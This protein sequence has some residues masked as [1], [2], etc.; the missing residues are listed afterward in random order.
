[1][2][3]TCYIPVPPDSVRAP[4]HRSLLEGVVGATV[5]A[6]HCHDPDTCRATLDWAQLLLA[7]TAFTPPDPATAAAAI[8]RQAHAYVQQQQQQQQQLLAAQQH[9]GMQGIVRQQFAGQGMFGAPQRPGFGGSGF[10]GL[11]GG[12]AAHAPYHNHQRGRVG[13][14]GAGV[15]GGGGAQ[16]SSFP[17]AGQGLAAL[18]RSCEG[19]P[20]L[21]AAYA[22]IGACLAAPGSGAAVLPAL[23]THQPLTH[24]H[25]HLQ[26]SYQQQQVHH[27]QQQ[28]LQL[29][30]QMQV[31]I[32]TQ[33]QQQQ[34]QQALAAFL[35]GTSQGPLPS[36]A[37]S[38][39]SFG[40]GQGTAAAAA[41]AATAAP[42]PAPAPAPALGPV[43]VLGLLVAASGAMPPD[44]ML[45][46][47][48][49]LHSAWQA[50]GA[51]RFRS[52]LVSAAFELGDVV[53]E[54]LAPWAKLKPEVVWAM[55]AEVLAEECAS[56]LLRFKRA[57]KAL[58]GGK[59][60][61]GGER[62]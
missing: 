33:Q 10:G 19:A 49:C 8:Q 17:G 20:A 62:E 46:I 60:K 37:V 13:G 35:G 43:L 34:Q 26:H 6:L 18:Q 58:C 39:L 36:M 41:M 42:A 50:M 29:Q 38:C 21:A 47:S 11:G 48:T 51:A 25:L 28:Q 61:I 52:W 16:P 7:A 31:H 15:A 9:H 24:Q 2:T 59:K 45:P 32:Q 3:P 12:G 14:V 4:L 57:L 27:Q 55:L 53:P 40:A 54:G 44:L 22:Q 56:D 23:R 30:L 1:M 5:A